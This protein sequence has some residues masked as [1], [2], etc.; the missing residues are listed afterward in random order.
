MDLGIFENKNFKSIYYI[1]RIND[2]ETGVVSNIRDKLVKGELEWDK[3]SLFYN[4]KD[5]KEKRENSLLDKLRSIFF[6]DEERANKYK[7]ELD[8]YNEKINNKLVSLNLIL[9]DFIV[10]FKKTQEGNIKTLED[11]IT[12]LKSGPI[13]LINKK[14]EEIENLIKQF[15]EGAK[16]RKEKMKSFF[17]INIYKANS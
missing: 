6:K 10:F 2:D 15:E 8:H 3:I 13:N 9:E 16:E 1:E 12:K 7:L 17:F 14:E 11:L 4:N 5:E